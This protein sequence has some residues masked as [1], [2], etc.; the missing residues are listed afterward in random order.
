MQPGAFF[1]YLWYTTPW[2]RE[3]THWV[4]GLRELLL[5]LNSYSLSVWGRQ[6]EGEDWHFLWVTD[7]KGKTTQEEKEEECVSRQI[8]FSFHISFP[9]FS[10]HNHVW[11]HVWIIYVHKCAYVW[12]GSLW[13][14]TAPST[15][16]LV[17]GSLFLLSTASLTHFSRLRNDISFVA[18]KSSSN[19]VT[20]SNTDKSLTV[21]PLMIKNPVF[22]GGG[23]LTCNVCALH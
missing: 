20:A 6:T 13:K 21:L 23:A 11:L 8:F 3:N 22:F 7:R 15:A 4:E 1:L 5:T 18:W 19:S 14:D 2:L 9:F 10:F 17:T 12:G 16:A